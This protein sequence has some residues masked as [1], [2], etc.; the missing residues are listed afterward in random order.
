MG[1]PPHRRHPD[2]DPTDPSTWPSHCG[3]C[4]EKLKRRQCMGHSNIKDDEGRIVG[5]RHCRCYAMVGQTKCKSHGGRS[6][7]AKAAAERAIGEAEARR[8]VA[9]YGL[10]VEVAPIDA[11]LQEL[12]RTAGHV[13]WLGVLIADLEHEESTRPAVLGAP[14]TGDEAEREATE[15]PSTSGRSGLKQYTR[16]KGLTWEKPSVWVE[17]YQTERK[18]L[19]SVAAA[20]IK[21]NVDERR[22]ELAEQQ[23]QLLAK[24]ISGIVGDLG[25][26]LH[27]A[28]VREVVT[29]HLQLVRA[30]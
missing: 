12:H 24:V 21:A 8:A 5:R 10:P 27:E 17:L 6:K 3:D 20:C 15:G 13:A 1:P 19:A 2:I 4:G 29:R 28:G 23:G 30:A 14:A 26:D 7:R 9:T 22:V 16:D 18:H 25:H 11:L